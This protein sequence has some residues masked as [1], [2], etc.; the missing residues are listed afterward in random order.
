[1][2]LAAP[3]HL[4]GKIVGSSRQRD[5]E[6]RN[7]WIAD[8][9]R[10]GHSIDE[11][12]QAVGLSDDGVKSIMYQHHIDAT[13]PQVTTIARPLLARGFGVEDIAV[14]RR[15]PVERV[16]ATVAAMRRSGEL[17]QIYTEVAP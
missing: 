10:A 16:R 11:V 14:M 8:Q 9:L 5:R 7:D 12:A 13:G 17:A 15:I 1:M 6:C 4:C 3:S 2:T